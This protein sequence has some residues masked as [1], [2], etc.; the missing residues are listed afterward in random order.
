VFVIYVGGDAHNAARRLAD[1]DE[2]HHRSVHMMCRLRA[3]SLGHALRDAL[4]NDHHRLG[5]TAIVVVEVASGD[6]RHAQRKQRTLAKWRETAREDLL[7]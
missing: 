7:L 2:I 1:V 3:S 6:N 4:A 5:A